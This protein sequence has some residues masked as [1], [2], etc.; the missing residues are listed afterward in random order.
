[1][2]NPAKA[3]ASP[4]Q[5]G[6][7]GSLSSIVCLRKIKSVKAERASFRLTTRSKD[8]Q[9]LSEQDVIEFLSPHTVQSVTLKEAKSPLDF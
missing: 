3:D 5:T 6:A 1:V 7:V 9:L 4:A 2:A 8:C